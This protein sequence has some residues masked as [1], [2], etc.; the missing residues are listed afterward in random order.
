MNHEIF[1]LNSFSDLEVELAK[2]M[3]KNKNSLKIIKD[4]Q[5][6]YNLLNDEFNYYRN[7]HHR[8]NFKYQYINV[9]KKEDPQT[10]KL[11]NRT[12]HQP[13]DEEN[14]ESLDLE[15]KYVNLISD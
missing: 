8:K 5:S 2:S 7:K 3:N 15:I 6:D 4:L 11:E 10:I 1:N 9:D 13:I 12:K 14:T